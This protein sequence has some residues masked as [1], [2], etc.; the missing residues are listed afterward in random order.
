LPPVSLNWQPSIVRIVWLHGPPAVGKSVTA[1]EVLNALTRLHPAIGYVD[2]DQLGMSYFDENEDPKGHRLKGRA[3]AAVAREF[4]GFGART[5]V[6]SGVVGLDLME[7]YAEELQP[8]DPGFVRL[9][10]SHAELRRRR[11]AR[12]EYA[13]EWSGV[14]EYARG[15]DVLELDHA[16]VDSGLGTPAEVA[17]RVLQVVE[18]WVE[19]DP[20]SPHTVNTS[21]GPEHDAEG[22]AVL[23]GGTTAVGKST[24]GWN[25]F[26]ATRERGQRSAFV[27]LRQLGFLGVG[28]GFID[29]RL[30]ARAASALW[31]VFKA[32]G[33][34]VLIM[35]GPVNTSAELLE[36]QAALANTPF[37]A[38]RL[39][40]Q[41][42]ALNERVRARLR[43]EMAPLAGDSLV[44]RPAAETGSIVDAAL[45]VQNQVEVDSAF[46]S[47]DSSALDAVESARRVLSGPQLSARWDGE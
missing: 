2:I 5:L 24:I 25:A 16:V 7:F 36:Y 35:N 32:H 13:E 8:F 44:G 10:A 40:A 37:A 39:T 3:L 4:A 45:Q 46:P 22:Q 31:R 30:Q 15:L 38:I 17:A 43:G 28:G 6:V 29:H 27:D 33:A 1:W 18:G 11:A 23:V 14:E 9:T 42:P 21:G 26:M 41:R 34:Q 47:L 12:G 20:P 19:E